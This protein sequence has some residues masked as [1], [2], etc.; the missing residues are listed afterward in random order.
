MNPGDPVWLRHTD[1]R[2]ILDAEGL[3]VTFEITAVDAIADNTWYRLTTDH[4]T[5]HEIFSGRYTRHRITPG[6]RCGV[7]S[8]ST[9]RGR[10]LW[11]RVDFQRGDFAKY[12]GTWYEVLRV[13]NASVTIPHLHLHVSGGVV[14]TGDVRPGWTWTAPYDGLAGRMSA[15][16]MQQRQATMEAPSNDTA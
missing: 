16:E 1:G 10:R 13:N 2:H 14:R 7:G 6:S 11:S 12:R 8:K 9:H 3:P 15:E 4:P 5:A